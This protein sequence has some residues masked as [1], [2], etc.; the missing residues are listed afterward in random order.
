[1]N[2]L[3]QFLGYKSGVKAPKRDASLESSKDT[4]RDKSI[5]SQQTDPSKAFKT[6]LKVSNTKNNTSE[7]DSLPSTS[8]SSLVSSSSL[9]N[10]SIKKTLETT[11]TSAASVESKTTSV[12]KLV[13]KCE[14]KGNDKNT[15]VHPLFVRNKESNVLMTGEKKENAE[16]KSTI[17]DKQVKERSDRPPKQSAKGVQPVMQTPFNNKRLDQEVV[18]AEQKPKRKSSA[19]SDSGVKNGK[20]KA[21]VEVINITDDTPARPDKNNQ[22]LKLSSTSG[23]SSSSSSSS[24]SQKGKSGEIPTEKVASFFMTPSQRQEQNEKRQ[25]EL[26]ELENLRKQQKFEENYLKQK[27]EAK[28]LSAQFANAKG[29]TSE[30]FKKRPAA[31]GPGGLKRE[32]SSTKGTA[33]RTSS[34]SSKDSLLDGPIPIEVLFP[35]LQHLNA[36]TTSFHID[37]VISST[38]SIPT[39]RVSSITS[40]TTLGDVTTTNVQIISSKSCNMGPSPLGLEFSRAMRVERSLWGSS[41]LR[42]MWTLY[43]SSITM[44]YRKS[45]SLD[46][47]KG[48]TSIDLTIDSK[49]P[50]S[51]S[52]VSQPKM[53]ISCGREQEMW[54]DK[55]R[56]RCASDVLGNTSEVQCIHEWL[57]Y[58]AGKRRAPR[59]KKRKRKGRNKT[60]SHAS[61][62]DDG[63]SQSPGMSNLMVVSGASGS[64]KTSAIYACAMEVGFHVL[65][66]NAGQDCSGKEVKKM[67]T[68]ATQSQGVQLDKM[69][70]RIQATGTSK[71]GNGQLSLILFED[72]DLSIPIDTGFQ[73]AIL[74]IAKVAKCPILLTTHEERPMEFL[75]SSSVNAPILVRFQLPNPM[76][77]LQFLSKV[78]QSCM[79]GKGEAS[80]VDKMEME[81]KTEIVD[82][83]D[84]SEMVVVDERLK[85]LSVMAHD[86]IKASL[87]NLQ[88][89][90]INSNPLFSSTGST[91]IN[92][93]KPSGFGEWLTSKGVD[94]A[95]FDHVH[96][97]A[98]SAL[99]ENKEQTSTYVEGKEGKTELVAYPVVIDVEP[100]VVSAQ[101]GQVINVT[102]RNF[103]QLQP[104]SS[105]SPSSS[106]LM[107]V[108]VEVRSVGRTPMIFKA[109]LLS[110]NEL[111]FT[112]PPLDLS[113]SELCLFGTIV[114]K[115]SNGH[116]TLSSEACGLG[117]SWLSIY[118]ESKKPMYPMLSFSVKPS[119]SLLRRSNSH[120]DD[121]DD[122]DDFAD[123]VISGV[124]EP[125]DW[126]SSLRYQT[127]QTILH[128]MN[129]TDGSQE[130][131]GTDGMS[132]ARPAKKSR[133]LNRKSTTSSDDSDD[134]FIN[135]DVTEKKTKTKIIS[136]GRT[137]KISRSRVVES[138][139]SDINEEVPTSLEAT[140]TK[141]VPGTST[142]TAA[143]A[144]D[145]DADGRN[146]QAE[147]FD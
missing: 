47:G 134:D 124:E 34:S 145:A 73:A 85:L 68:E 66:I 33:S 95:C 93:S 81:T 27:K 12:S 30:F 22:K 26:L 107:E 94:F 78:T 46:N 139:D 121:G 13:M 71:A 77:I 87:A 42:A 67:V 102:G 84:K 49:S 4:S 74:Y 127:L 82:M 88:V 59:P 55:Y 137:S 21:K 48:S 117:Q 105:S 32:N 60:R 53:N 11:T 37:A 108:S 31:T 29:A 64:G 9:S 96:T 76:D 115:L 56:P 97:D 65:E 147:L 100:R 14:M 142:G 104:S 36:V 1:M 83:V 15:K 119:R 17:K 45:S 106:Q 63:R 125:I 52:V 141:D 28:A 80:A 3:D 44:D 6:P 57:Q 16:P 120:G 113:E 58:W 116:A 43:H 61:D 130:K 90:L 111:A 69:D 136:R 51:S 79:S 135:H 122:D 2:F 20:D 118:H 62:W 5:A 128:W 143:I 35:S 86:D 7:R 41:V 144:D 138:D 109:I 38:A 40:N 133:K 131:K 92:E 101:I 114:V 72:A 98:A 10:G 112:L 146:K 70:T 39:R 110:D 8:S 18:T 103:T 91:K 24:S 89:S 19:M 54:A 140:T 126:E 23:S 132:N 99:V 25:K 50:S 123:Q 129:D 75:R